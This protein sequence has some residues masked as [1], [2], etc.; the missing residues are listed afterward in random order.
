VYLSKPFTKFIALLLCVCQICAVQPSHAD[1][2][3][4]DLP[5]AGSP[6]TTD[7]GHNG[8]VGYVPDGTTVG[9]TYVDENGTA[10]VATDH[11]T[12]LGHDMLYFE[13]F[14]RGDVETPSLQPTDK[15]EVPESDKIPEFKDFESSKNDFGREVQNHM[16]PDHYGE[17]VT[18][19][20]Q[21][22][23][24]ERSQGDTILGF[25]PYP[26]KSI[27][28][29]NAK[30]I[31][32]LD[33]FL[34]RTLEKLGSVEANVL[35]LA[36]AS[37]SQGAPVGAFDCRSCTNPAAGLDFNDEADRASRKNLVALLNNQ[38]LKIDPSLE[39]HAFTM[40]NGPDRRG[41]IA[42]YERLVSAQ[43]LHPQG[44]TARVIGMRAV[45]AADEASTT[46]DTV[47]FSFNKEIA[48]AMADIALGLSPLGFAKDTYEAIS[49]HAFVDG[50]ELSAFERGVAV[51]GAVTLGIAS[52]PGLFAKAG[53]AIVNLAEATR[54]SERTIE[55]L[56]KTVIA[57][58]DFGVGTK[59][60]FRKFV[61]FS[62]RTLGSAVGKIGSDISQLGPKEKA[63]AKLHAA[64]KEL[65]SELQY[66]R[67]IELGSGDHFAAIGRHMG[68]KPEPGV[69]QLAEALKQA[70]IDI[71][72]FEPKDNVRREFAALKAAAPGGRLTDSELRA[73]MMFQENE[74]W[75]RKCLEDGYTIIDMGNP[76]GKEASV[77]YEM[78]KLI[79]S[80]RVKK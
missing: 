5:N 28:P 43:P 50:R 42:T 30:Y 65:P 64:L 75:I 35:G 59:E 80:E 67:V 13:R 60:A 4:V 49:G 73:T 44:Q 51:F 76:Y 3:D 56:A 8:K 68:S 2:D 69:Q 66:E 10:W 21:Y 40:P 9:D 36:V 14:E 37:A 6:I 26:I 12:Y 1:A 25:A 55:G 72:I 58:R 39:H 38:N 45:V 7:G 20:E 62:R 19:T 53:A 47:M 78:E 70:G 32:A 52:K 54:V 48:S 71:E 46:G 16:G 74:N 61:D 11:D 18:K 63:F 23:A 57:A 34:G 29:V 41:L 33:G 24:D 22:L 79:L 77:F 27:E 31:A 15:I 17:W